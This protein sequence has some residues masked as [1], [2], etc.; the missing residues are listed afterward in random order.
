MKRRAVD[1]IP[2]VGRTPRPRRAN[3]AHPAHL[4]ATTAATW[5]WAV[6]IEATQ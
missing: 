3:R 4:A 1:M 5:K 2:H 6:V